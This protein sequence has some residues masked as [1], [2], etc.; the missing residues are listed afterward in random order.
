MFES[1]P[2]SPLHS[3]AESLAQLPDDPRA[4]TLR[5]Q[6]TCS[7][8][9]SSSSKITL[10]L[11]TKADPSLY[12]TVRSGKHTAVGA[13]SPTPDASASLQFFGPQP[14]SRRTLPPSAWSTRTSA[15][16][17]LRALSIPSISRTAPSSGSSIS[18]LAPS[19]ISPAAASLL[20]FD[21][22]YAPRAKRHATSD[23]TPAALAALERRSRL[24]TSRVFCATCRTPGTNFP[25]CAR[26]GNA[27]CSR[28]CRL[29]N[30]ARHVC[31]QPA[32]GLSRT[33]ISCSP[34]P[35][36]APA[37]ILTSVS[38]ATPIPSR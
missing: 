14:R 38:S 18:D 32:Q 34:V 25:A 21:R 35:M 5:R 36:S 3:P 6:R 15:P 27:W 16:P 17:P 19:P 31:P 11:P 10:D 7:S 9:V 24:C 20:D 28:A 23:G 4:R 8:L 33:G 37:P 2:A 30:G 29:P 12:L 1:T 22:A 13:F 26:C